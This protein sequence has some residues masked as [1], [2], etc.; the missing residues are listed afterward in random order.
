MGAFYTRVAG[1]GFENLPEGTYTVRLELIS[2]GR[3]RLDNLAFT[4]DPGSALEPTSWGKIKALW[5]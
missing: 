3:H 5:R 2:G 1:G 4:L